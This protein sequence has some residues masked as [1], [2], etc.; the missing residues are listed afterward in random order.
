MENYKQNI[1]N[2]VRNFLVE[3]GN[4]VPEFQNVI[5]E[6]YEGLMEEID[7]IPMEP[8]PMDVDTLSRASSRAASI[9]SNT[10]DNEVRKY[11]NTIFCYFKKDIVLSDFFFFLI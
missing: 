2:V 1:V 5:Q 8:I 10:N 3:L 4:D 11:S 6:R 7:L 9:T